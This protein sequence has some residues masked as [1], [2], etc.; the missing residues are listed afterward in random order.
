MI[1]TTIYVFMQLYSM[2]IFRINRWLGE[3][4]N[5]FAYSKYYK[6]LWQ[7]NEKHKFWCFWCYY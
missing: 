6:I 4:R 7:Y 2:L 1:V 5:G 3:S